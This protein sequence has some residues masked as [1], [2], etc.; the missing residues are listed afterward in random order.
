MSV[1]VGSSKNTN[2]VKT[3]LKINYAVKKI[4]NP[5]IK[6]KY[7]DVNY[8]VRHAVGIDTSDLFVAKTGIRDSNDLVWV[9]PAANYAAKLCSLRED[10]NSSWIS[11]RIFNNIAN[12]AKYGGT[13]NRLMWEAR[14][15]TKYNQ[16]VYCSNWTWTV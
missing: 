6:E 10:A 8:E 14:T 3:A 15:W 2:S 12:E 13:D 1:F 7:P 16:T 11:A 9:G 5:L 4:I